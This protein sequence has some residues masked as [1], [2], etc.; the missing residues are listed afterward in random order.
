MDRQAQRCLGVEKYLL[1]NQGS[2]TAVIVRITAD[3]V[4]GIG[5]WAS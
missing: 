4:T 2:P 3:R 5:P 1:G